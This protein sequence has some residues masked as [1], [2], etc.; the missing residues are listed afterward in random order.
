MLRVEVDA[1]GRY[2]DAQRDIDQTVHLIWYVRCKQRTGGREQFAIQPTYNVTGFLG[3]TRES[4]Q[5][6]AQRAVGIRQVVVRAVGACRKGRGR[7]EDGLG[8]QEGLGRDQMEIPAFITDDDP[9]SGNRG[10]GQHRV[11]HANAVIGVAVVVGIRPPA[12]CN[13]RGANLDIFTV[14]QVQHASCRVLGGYSRCTAVV[15]RD[16]AGRAAILQCQVQRCARTAGLRQ[17]V[18]DLRAVRQGTQR[19]HTRPCRC[20]RG[21][22]A[23]NDVSLCLQLLHRIHG[24]SS[25]PYNFPGRTVPAVQ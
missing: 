5:V 17:P 14:G 18:G 6:V 2:H 13:A 1:V 15:E 24:G 11:A 25:V 3:G 16:R 8:D 9:G 21:L 22:C 20:S 4:G 19:G 10:F 12:L 7:P 23:H